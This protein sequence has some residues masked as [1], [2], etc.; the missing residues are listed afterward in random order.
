MS[1]DIQQS[2]HQVVHTT[3][4]KQFSMNYITTLYFN[5]YITK[6][7]DCEVHTT[8]KQRNYGKADES[9]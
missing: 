1:S 2:A 9:K 4:V 6:I 8:E 3:G 7:K 5:K